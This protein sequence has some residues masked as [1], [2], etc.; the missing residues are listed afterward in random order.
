MMGSAFSSYE[1]RMGWKKGE[2]RSHDIH[3]IRKRAGEV[4]RTRDGSRSNS[5]TFD[6]H[7]PTVPLSFCQVSLGHE[8]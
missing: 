1:F 4:R 3:N 5:G 7:S 6:I 2:H 8:W